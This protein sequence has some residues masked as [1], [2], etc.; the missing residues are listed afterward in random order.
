MPKYPSRTPVTSRM[1]YEPEDPIVI[2]NS[3]GE[4]YA[5]ESQY[6]N[7]SE[8]SHVGTLSS[9]DDDETGEHISRVPGFNRFIY[10]G[11]ERPDPAPVPPIAAPQPPIPR[12]VPDPQSGPSAP[13]AIPTLVRPKSLFRDI[14]NQ[15][16]AD[17]HVA[18]WN[19]VNGPDPNVNH[20][21]LAI[22]GRHQLNLTAFDSTCAE[23]EQQYYVIGQ[24]GQGF[25]YTKVLKAHDNL[26][27]TSHRLVTQYGQARRVYVDPVV[28]ADG[29]ITDQEG[30]PAE[31]QYMHVGP[32]HYLH[33]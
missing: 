9:I 12:L 10:S 24:H 25:V 17:R 15:H 20:D 4:C 7:D 2:S 14:F 13:P 18:E 5:P 30:G 23:T 22:A 16:R 1:G 3:D 31:L 28:H 33:G 8:Y 19:Q 6:G 27:R 11:L 21:I 29:T 26:L 32:I